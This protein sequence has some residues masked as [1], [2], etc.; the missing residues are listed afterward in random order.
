MKQRKSSNHT[1]WLLIFKLFVML[2]YSV[3]HCMMHIFRI[4]C[5]NITYNAKEVINKSK[6]YQSFLFLIV[7]M[8]KFNEI[9]AFV[10]KKFSNTTLYGLVTRDVTERLKFIGDC[11]MVL[12]FIINENNKYSYIM[13]VIFYMVCCLN[14]KTDMLFSY[15]ALC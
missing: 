5:V 14:Y 10:F 12:M 6:Y 2:F 8:I 9:K 15:R 1:P 3:T 11:F 13:K 7:L 4:Q